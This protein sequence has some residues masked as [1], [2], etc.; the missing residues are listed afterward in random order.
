MQKKVE[1]DIVIVGGGVAGLWLLNRLRQQKLSAILLEA[2][3]LG[4]G[5]THKAQGIIHGGMKFALTG[6]NQAATALAEIP[7]LWESCLK[8]EGDLNLQ[9]V[10]IL[11]SKQYL[12]SP[13]SLAG[14][15]AGFLAGLALRTPVDS[16]SRQDFPEVFRSPQF[17]GAMYALP[18][19]VIDVH[20]LVREL[21]K[22]HQDAIFKIKPL[23]EADLLL[24]E[25][26]QM[27]A[28]NIQSALPETLMLTAQQY[29][30]TAGIG[31]EVLL[32]KL[33]IKSIAAQ[34][35]PLH[36]VY[37]KLPQAYSLFAHCLSM[38]STPRLTITT[39]QTKEGSL[40]YLGGHLAEIGVTR[41]S[42][43]QIKAAQEELA[44]LFPWL[45]FSKAQFG[46]CKIDRAEPLQPKGGRPDSYCIKAI[47]NMMVAWPTK[48]AFA[49]QLAND[50][51]SQLKIQPQ[52]CNMRE[53]RACPMPPL[54]EPL[55]S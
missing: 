23:S 27:R 22:P 1:T 11:S 9:A 2:K 38:S 8:G 37:V 45:D 24:D 49:P 19:L 40:W 4:G 47:H 30:F 16:L 35:R 48:L 5:Q 36:M 7:A 55:W 39:H 14:K 28:L 25:S 31:N 50:I 33:K 6:F 18:E 12:W 29:I 43:E 21:A 17:D 54:A 32:N 13:P 44:L 52:F 26:G 41:S 46:S 3:A 42:E 20:A 51:L 53:L 10:P 15:F 34:R